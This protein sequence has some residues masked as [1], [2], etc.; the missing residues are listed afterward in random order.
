[1]RAFFIWTGMEIK[2]ELKYQTKSLNYGEVKSDKKMLE[3]AFK[4][5]KKLLE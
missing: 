1:M 2:F 4:A 3:E 5:G